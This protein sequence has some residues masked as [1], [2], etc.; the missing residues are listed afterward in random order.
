MSEDSYYY[1]DRFV[2]VGT[3]R[4]IWRDDMD[5][6]CPIQGTPKKGNVITVKGELYYVY[7]ED[8]YEDSYVSNWNDHGCDYDYHI[9]HTYW[10]SMSAPPFI[11]SLNDDKSSCS[12]F[13]YVGSEKMVEVPN[14]IEGMLVV[15][16]HDN[17]FNNCTIESVFIPASVT[18][19]SKS[20]FVGC[21]NLK[22]IVVDENNKVYDSRDNCQAII[23]TATNSLF[24]A[25]KETIIP[26]TVSKVDRDAIKLISR[27]AKA[28]YLEIVCKGWA[29]WN[30]V[31]GHNVTI[32]VSNGFMTLREH[33]LEVRGIDLVSFLTIESDTIPMTID[34]FLSIIKTIFSESPYC[35]DWFC[36]LLDVNKIAY[37]RVEK[38]ILLYFHGFGSSGESS[39]V[40]TLQ[41]LLPD[42]IVIAPD[43]PVDPGEAWP[44]L[45]KMCDAIK[46]DIVVGTSMGG[47]YAHQ[48][49][50]FKRICINPAFYM[51]K[52]T[53]S[54]GKKNVFSRLFKKPGQPM[55]KQGTFEFLN[56]RRNGEK[57]FVITYEIIQH[58]AK[59]ESLQFACVTKEDRENVYGLFADNDTAV[60]CKGIFRKYYKNAHLISFHGEHRLNRLVI[61]EVLVPLIQRLASR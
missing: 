31:I 13:K 47:M 17:A 4:V 7:D 37:E 60:N 8:K 45:K 40:K 34:D 59:M 32:D 28:K 1:H 41:E 53:E 2:E 22:S 58:F 33:Q 9:Y 15:A 39:T 14:E 49:S 52:I 43:I 46:P 50:G 20:A 30:E 38:K 54:S 6:N 36:R 5:D 10:L 24:V 12:L 55:L 11:A 29:V 3:H 42:W 25:C 56:P 35:L 19:L 26:E 51:S 21:R 61:E 48:M 23:E 18:Q 16:I 27:K 57:T 44:F